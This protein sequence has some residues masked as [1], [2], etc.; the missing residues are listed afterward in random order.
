MSKDDE[1]N[2]QQIL[3]ANLY[4]VQ[5]RFYEDENGVRHYHYSQDIADYFKKAYDDYTKII[6][7][8]HE[9]NTKSN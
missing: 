3:L 6:W 9:C 2:I 7:E 8:K 1:I 5:T 4:Q